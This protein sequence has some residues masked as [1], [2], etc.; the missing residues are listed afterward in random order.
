MSFVQR[1]R[2]LWILFLTGL[3][4]LAIAANAETLSQ[5]G[6]EELN[7]ATAI[8]RVRSIGVESRWQGGELWT[9]TRLEIMELNKGLLPGVISI[10]MLGG[11]IRSPHSRLEGTPAFREGQ[12]AYV[13]LWRREGEP[14]RVPGWS[15]G[16]FR[17]TRDGSVT[18]FMR[19]R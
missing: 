17:I 12:E 16:A 13:F 3:T 15:E 14:F 7:Q 2:F 18:P 6:F 4:L 1:R 19:K 5:L 9:E 11:N 8:A 10:R